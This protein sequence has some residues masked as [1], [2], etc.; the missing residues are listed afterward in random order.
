M[1]RLAMV[2]FGV[3]GDDVGNHD[4]ITETRDVSRAPGRRIVP[5]ANFCG[6]DGRRRSSSEAPCTRVRTGPAVI[7][8]TEL[9]SSEAVPEG[10]GA[11]ELYD[12]PAIP[13]LLDN[14]SREAGIRSDLKRI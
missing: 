5:V 4:R 14:D 7:R 10:Q 6:G 8:R 12:V 9:S 1:V 2:A 13:V 3:H 11:R